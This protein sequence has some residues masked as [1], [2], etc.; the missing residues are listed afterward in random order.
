MSEEEKTD[1]AAAED[2]DDETPAEEVENT[3]NFDPVV[4]TD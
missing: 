2:G 1:V 4:S 3:T